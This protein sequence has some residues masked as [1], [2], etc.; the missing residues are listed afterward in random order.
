MTQSLC[1]FRISYGRA[2]A[3]ATTARGRKLSSETEGDEDSKVIK[4]TTAGRKHVGSRLG[5][6]CRSEFQEA[7]ESM[8]PLSG[9]EPSIAWKTNSELC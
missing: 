7:S 6:Y 9:T 2:M 3:K 4:A 8:E 1:S 5:V